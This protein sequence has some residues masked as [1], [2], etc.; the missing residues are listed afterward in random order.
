MEN[1]QVKFIPNAAR[2]ILETNPASLPDGK[3]N[4]EPLKSLAKEAGV[5]ASIL[6]DK[7]IRQWANESEVHRHEADLWIGIDGTAH[8]QTGGTLVNP[9]AKKNADGSVNDREL[10][11]KRIEGGETYTVSA[12]DILY[13]PAGVPHTHWTE[14]A[15]AARLWIIKIPATE[16]PLEKVHGWLI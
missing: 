9:Y 13:I 15:G 14:G 3:Q 12:G 7:N 10:K 4:P 16:Y 5:P 2:G 11:A 8:F 1:P 6:V